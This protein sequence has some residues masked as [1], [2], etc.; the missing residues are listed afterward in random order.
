MSADEHDRSLAR[1]RALMA[2]TVTNGCSPEEELAAARQVGRLISQMDG[3]GYGLADDM[4]L[5][6]GGERQS[7]GYRDSLE[8]NTLEGLFKSAVQELSLAHINIVSPPRRRP[9]GQPVQWVQ[10]ADLLQGHLV[11]ALGIAGSRLGR[12]ILVRTIEELIQ[13]GMLPDRLAVPLDV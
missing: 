4:A 11:M 12:E 6:P 3:G 10:V 9:A 2:H 5:E 8:K 1:L 13:D 7:A